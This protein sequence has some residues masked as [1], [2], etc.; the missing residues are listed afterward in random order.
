VRLSLEEGRVIGCLI[1]KQ[2]TT[3]QLYP[4]SLHAVV[5]ACN[6]SSNRQPVVHYDQRGVQDALASLK[7]AGLV[8]YVHPSHGR[9]VIRFRHALDERLGL[10]EAGLALV[11][12]L[13]LRGEQTAGE[14]R[15]RTDRMANFETIAAV[16]GELERMSAGAEPLVLRLRRRPGQKEERWVQLLTPAEAG[17]DRSQTDDGDAAEAGAGDSRARGEPDRGHREADDRAVSYA[18]AGS[19]RFDSPVRADDQLAALLEAVSSLSA[20]VAELRVVV[21]QLQADHPD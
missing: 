19:R 3:P 9:S 5:S 1:E 18:G 17:A 11:C 8:R 10:D 6:Q 12:V 13:L 2:L 15:A 7:D 14:L 21:Q 4:L 16:D 20:E